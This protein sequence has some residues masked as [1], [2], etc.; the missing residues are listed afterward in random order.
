MDDSHYTVSRPVLASAVP[1]IHS[2]PGCISYLC[3]L[4]DFCQLTISSV[5]RLDV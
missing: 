3:Y 1:G 4:C 2:I 5:D